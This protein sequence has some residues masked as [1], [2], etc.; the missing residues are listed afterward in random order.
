M[1]VLI[2][3]VGCSQKKGVELHA[4][5][6]A[7]A[8]N[9]P[10]PLA[11]PAGGA[12]GG[13]RSMMKWSNPGPAQL[14]AAAKTEQP[15]QAEPE[16]NTETYDRIVDN[17]FQAAATSPLSTFA[18]DVD[19]ASLS[20]IRRFLNE[21]K[22]PPV[23]AVRIEEMINYFKYNYPEPNGQ[24]PIGITTELGTC[25]WK[26]DHWLLRIGMRAKSI[27]PD[28][29]P[30]RNFVFLVDVSG[31]M[32]APNRL[33]LVKQGFQFLVPQLTEKDRVAIVVYAGDS[34]VALP[35]T[36]GDQHDRIL[37]TIM[38]LQASGST[39]GGEGI[40]LAYRIA[41]QNYIPGGVN[42]VILSTDGDFN[43]GV[44]SQGELIRMIEEKRKDNIFLTILGFGMGNL[45]D[46]TLEKLAD[47]GNGHYAYID[48]LE[49]AKKVFL[50]D[51][52][53]LVTMAK[54]VKLQVE[55]NPAKVQAYRLIGYENRVMKNQE[56]HDDS[57]SGGA[58]GA[59]HTVTALYEIVP[60]GVNI[61]LPMESKL[62]YQQAA[63]SVTTAQ[64]NELGFIK[65]RYKDPEAEQS[66][67]FDQPISSE[68]T[69]YE[70]CSSDFR[71]ASGMASFG[72]VLRNSPHK[73]DSTYQL[74]GNLLRSGKGRDPLG[75]RAEW[76]PLS[77]R[78][79]EVNRNQRPQ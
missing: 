66:Q 13:G 20:N 51:G 74:V 55:F 14:Q 11:S 44:T 79:Q 76:T 34:G 12:T 64:S 46:A 61:D 43:V 17:T 60:I 16:Y 78:A 31:S 71:F 28:H 30:P 6:L 47:K 2:W 39:N 62:R 65:V 50:T 18:I 25:P 54:D 49:E 36:R 9:E 1:V 72:M 15:A 58:I 32:S 63:R 8:S 67:L 56:F 5:A 59:G 57:K 48:T 73:G 53:A 3:M 23:D 4:K 38:R 40:Q 69:P 26:M 24:H 27:D 37:E 35:T 29:M 42:R 21:D 19:T 41:K 75:Q 10:T 68:P 7:H 77:E 45:K 22:M 33:P 70:S 52:A